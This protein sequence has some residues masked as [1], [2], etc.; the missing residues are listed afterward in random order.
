[1]VSKILAA[2]ALE[3]QGLSMVLYIGRKMRECS[4]FRAHNLTAF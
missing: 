2:L 3:G 4:I 1:M